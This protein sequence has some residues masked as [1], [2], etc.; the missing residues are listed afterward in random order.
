MTDYQPIDCHVHDEFE[1]AIMRGKPVLAELLIDGTWVKMEI[2]PRDTGVADG[3][4][5]LSYTLA[6]QDEIMQVRL[7]RVRLVS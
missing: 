7:D 2:L 1:I 6:A 5:F 4:E 3:E